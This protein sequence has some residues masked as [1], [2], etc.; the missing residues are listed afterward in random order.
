MRDGLMFSL[1]CAALGEGLF[2][3]LLRSWGLT[4]LK[5]RLPS[6]EI[7]AQKRRVDSDSEA[8]CERC[9]VVTNRPERT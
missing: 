6:Y 3:F 5:V 4:G 2:R 7:G 1:R 9:P 8:I